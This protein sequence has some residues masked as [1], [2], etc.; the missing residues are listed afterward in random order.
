[1]MANPSIPAPRRPIKAEERTFQYGLFECSQDPVSLAYAVACPCVLF[2]KNSEQLGGNCLFYGTLHCF[3]RC[4]IHGIQR[5]QLRD[6]FGIEEGSLSK[7]C[8]LTLCC[9]PCALVQET[10]EIRYQIQKERH[11]MRI[12][13]KK[14]LRPT[15]YYQQGRTQISSKLL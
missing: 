10:Q 9:D 14:A 13:T 8:W 1:M 11:I 5:K 4:V 6:E 2:G 7:D 15:G 3:T 12:R